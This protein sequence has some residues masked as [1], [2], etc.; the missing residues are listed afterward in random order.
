M[1]VS[2]MAGNVAAL[3]IANAA[4]IAVLVSRPPRE[5]PPALVSF[6]AGV[7]AANLLF[8]D[9]LISAIGLGAIN[10]VEGLVA[11]LVIRPRLGDRPDFGD[12][13]DLVWFVL[14]A[15][16]VA[17]M[18]GAMLGVLF[19]TTLVGGNVLELWVAWRAWFLADCLGNLAFAPLFTMALGGFRDPDA[20][21][22]PASPLANF[23]PLAVVGATSILV[24]AQPQPV[25][26]LLVAA[27]LV[28]TFRL[29][30]RGAALAIAIVAL[31]GG[32]ATLAGFGPF[33]VAGRSPAQ[34]G[35]LFQLLL[36]VLFLCSLPVAAVLAERSRLAA[37]L[38]EGEARY[39]DL[40]DNIGD[41][42]YVTDAEF[43]FTALNTAWVKLTGVPVAAGIGRMTTDFIHPDD[44]HLLIAARD[45]LTTSGER[46]TVRSLTI[47]G[48]RHMSVL[49][50]AI[51][52]DAGR[53][54]GTRGTATDVTAQVEAEAAL[55]LAA[56]TDALTGLANRRR[57]LAGLDL[58]LVNADNGGGPLSLVLLDVDRFKAVNDQYGHPAGDAVLVAIARELLSIAGGHLAARFGGEEFALVLPGFDARAAHEFSEVLRARIA[59]RTLHPVPRVTVSLGIAERQ[60]GEGAATLIARADA[61]LYAAKAAGRN[62]VMRA[63]A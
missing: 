31:I 60:P 62:Q 45:R 38:A 54:I 34:E 63:A 4:L 15:A 24:F 39:R 47:N 33:T 43:R 30:P 58:A 59:A 6:A 11:G 18:V 52:D 28:A 5:W 36:G 7:T 53:L 29:G 9:S 14:G 17:P 57:L 56:E 55:R 3:W 1:L 27:T 48:V 23:W 22:V 26:Y 20:A 37:R 12:R 41:L 8:G 2:R 25:A 50:H 13:S 10:T 19:H 40:V 16:F 32:G 44:R 51:R 21:S 35:A 42:V 61:A 46:V 49:A